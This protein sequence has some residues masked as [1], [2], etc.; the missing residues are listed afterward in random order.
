MFPCAIVRKGPVGR[1]SSADN[2]IF[3]LFVS[4]ETEEA[5][6]FTIGETFNPASP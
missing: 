4:G 5:S 6:P 1:E 3:Q 2:R